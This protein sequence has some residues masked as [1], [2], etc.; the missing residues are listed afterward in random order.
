MLC[1]PCDRSWPRITGLRCEV[2]S[3][4]FP[5]SDASLVCQNCAERNFHFVASLSPLRAHGAVREMVHRLKYNRERWLARPLAECMAEVGTD[6]RLP[7]TRV[8]LLVPVPLH[9]LRQRE[10]EFNQ[11]ELL[12]RE[13]GRR[14]Q[15]PVRRLLRRRNYTETQT[16]F[17]RQVR[18]QNL[19]GAFVLAQNA[20][21]DSMNIVLVD[22]VFTTGSTLDECARTLLEG[23]AAAVWAVTAARA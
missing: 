6:E 8:D 3:Q 21:C 23:G 17:D 20:N 7:L 18:M 10:R 13:L 11:A 22:D 14:W 15:K 5:A 9:A 1:G 16:H 4:P 19:R 2:C 12:A